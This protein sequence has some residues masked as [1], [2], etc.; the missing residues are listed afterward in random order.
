MLA[1]SPVSRPLVSV[2]AVLAFAAPAFAD[3]PPPVQPPAVQPAAAQAPSSVG[4]PVPPPADQPTPPPKPRVRK[5][6]VAEVLSPV[7]RIPDY[8]KV[9]LYKAQELPPEPTIEPSEVHTVRVVARDEDTPV[10]ARPLY[11]AP[12][13]GAVVPG[14]RL[15][16]K[17]VVHSETP[18]GCA[19]RLWYALDPTGY[20]CSRELRPTD[21][22]PTEGPLLKLGDGERLPYHYQMVLVPEGEQVPLWASLDDLKA[23]KDPERQLE[24]GDSVAVHKSISVGGARYWVSVDGKVFPAQGSRDMGQAS[25]WHGEPLDAQAHFPFGWTIPAVVKAWP[26]PAIKGKPARTL[27]PRTRLDILEERVQR[28]DRWLRVSLPSAATDTAAAPTEETPLW[29]RA[30]D[31]DEARRI[32]RPD[33]IS[34]AAQWIDVDLGEQVLVA[35]QGAEPVY[36]TLVSSGRGEH[37]TP[38]GNYP[39]WDK[40]TTISMKSQPYEEKTYFV[41]KVPWVLFFQAHNAIHGAYWHDRFGVTKSHGCVN[42]APLDAHWIFDWVSL[43]LPPGWTGYRPTDLRQ[44]PTVHVRNSHKKVELVQDRPIGPPDRELETRKLED[45]EAARAAGTQTTLPSTAP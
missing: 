4:E 3:T 26:A 39:I 1:S 18:R 30:R 29:V 2:A 15:P 21:E 14:A 16:V 6:L 25:A 43:P 28:R 8:D 33:G 12:L 9:R 27:A 17:G 19:S 42:L 44:S 40:T 11:G 37:Q 31:V 32:A 38:R 35:Y 41:D 13:L 45:A 36:A 22:P 24:R 34:D 5:P 23:H 7:R 20:V 10:F